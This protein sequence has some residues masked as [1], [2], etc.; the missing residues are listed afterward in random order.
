MK[1]LVLVKCT[2][3]K[4]LLFS[5]DF[6]QNGDVNYDCQQRKL[7]RLKMSLYETGFNALFSFFLARSRILITIRIF[8]KNVPAT[9]NYFK[10][11]QMCV[12]EFVCLY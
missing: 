11:L 5:Y 7:S 10:N 2:K 9:K 12:F 6:F 1:L 8:K 4:R 3:E